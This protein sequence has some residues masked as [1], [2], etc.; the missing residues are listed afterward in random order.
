MQPSNAAPAHGS[1]DLHITAL[2]K[3]AVAFQSDAL[4]GEAAPD[5]MPCRRP[6]AGRNGTAKET[7]HHVQR[8]LGDL[9]VRVRRLEMTA[10]QVRIE[11]LLLKV[12]G[13]GAYE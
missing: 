4:L 10:Q 3:A 13:K 7:R 1:D 9:P 11:V 5:K 12:G 8:L 6:I 2:G